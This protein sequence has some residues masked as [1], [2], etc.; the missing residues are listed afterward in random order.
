MINASLGAWHGFIAK[1]VPERYEA[2][3]IITADGSTSYPLPADHYQTIGV[4]YQLTSNCRVA[5]KR[6]M[7]Q[8]RNAYSTDQNVQAEGYRLKGTT[9]VLLPPPS[10]GTYYHV[11]V[12]AAPVL[13]QPSDSIDA[14]NGWEEWI[15]YDVAIKM[16]L[17]EESDA[18]ALIAER[19]KI[20]AEMEAAAAE[21]E[22]GQPSRVV[23]TRTGRWGG[24]GHK[25]DPDFWAGR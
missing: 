23:D 3:Q 15:V 20:Q 17:K 5:L 24:T 2:E 21:R 14:V 19:N 9:L 6:L 7:V 22:A 18:S 11:Y 10:S 13:T 16:L 4:D 25:G 12:T 1:A 8:E